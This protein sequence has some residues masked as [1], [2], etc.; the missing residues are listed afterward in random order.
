MECGLEGGR[1]AVQAG[2]ALSLS[3]QP[4]RKKER[5]IREGREEAGGGEK[6]VPHGQLIPKENWS[7]ERHERPLV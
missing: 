3:Q 7:K 4:R 5:E 6:L 1:E 2:L